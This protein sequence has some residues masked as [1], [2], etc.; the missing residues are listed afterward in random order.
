[1]L[2]QRSP[3]LPRSR[4]EVYQARYGYKQVIARLK[5]SANFG[6]DGPSN[7]AKVYD[8][9]ADE[10]GRPYF[11]MEYVKG[12]PITDYADI[13]HFNDPGTARTL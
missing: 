12:R 2:E 8:A 6:F 7:I 5:L 4:V 1:M 11:V 3:I 10:S 9:G 13:N